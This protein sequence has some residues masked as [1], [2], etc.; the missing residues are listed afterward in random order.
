MDL[1]DVLSM[2][3]RVIVFSSVEDRCFYTW[4]Q[5]ATLQCW[6]L[7]KLY[8]EEGSPAGEWEECGIQT[9]SVEPRN[10]EEAVKAA[11][12]WYFGDT[13]EVVRPALTKKQ[14]KKIRQDYRKQ[15]KVVID[16]PAKIKDTVRMFGM[17]KKRAKK[18]KK[19]VKRIVKDNKKRG[20]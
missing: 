2:G 5:S 10:F 17:S 20:R 8:G 4:N 16:Q 6:T 3:E 19:M 18:I 9:L 12:N 13:G 7:A 11:R 15:G 14:V 1:F